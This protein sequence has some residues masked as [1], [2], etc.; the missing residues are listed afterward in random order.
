[1][2]HVP[3][4]LLL[5]LALC[6]PTAPAPGAPRRA[7]STRTNGHEYVSVASWAS[8]RDVE[9]RWL[10]REDTL[11]LTHGGS[12]VSLKVNARNAE[13]NGVEVWLSFPVLLR[14][15]QPCV[16][17]LD[18]ESAL[19]PLL[20]SRARRASPKLKHI[21][22]DPGHGGKDPGYCVG[23][24][25]EKKY[26]LLLAQELRQQLTSAGFK[27]SL[28]RSSDRFVDL[29]VRPELARLRGADLFVS[30]HFN[31][32][33]VARGTVQGSQVFCLTPPGASSTNA[34]GEGGGAGWFPGNRNNDDNLLLAFSLQKALTRGLAVE[35][36]GVRRARFAVLRDATMPAA[37]VEAGF[38]SHPVEG[39]KIFSAGYRRQLA[40]AVTQGIV[41][42]KQTMER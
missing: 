3:L 29:P 13:A 14:A 22:L 25:Q 8:G 23:S 33:E 26:T 41:A 39:R 16:A 4:P 12:K 10:N 5:A 18:A 34:G 7:L 38:M 2:K 1:M 36:H 11:Q 20:S 9:W 28:T 21:C 30:L 6:G 35:D 40:Q 19:E 31:A 32:T 17:R 27:V 24:N 15:G 42:Y 37:L